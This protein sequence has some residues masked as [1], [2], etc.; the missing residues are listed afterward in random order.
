MPFEAYR[1]AGQYRDKTRN[2]REGG[3]EVDKKNTPEP[4]WL[5]YAQVAVRTGF[6][7]STIWRASR[8]GDLPYGGVD[9]A[10]RFHA[11]DVDAWMRRGG[12][13]QDR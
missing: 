10:P 13:G 6:H 11:D 5:S 1:N 4:V 3:V 8:R 7:R 2:S 12:S 9:G